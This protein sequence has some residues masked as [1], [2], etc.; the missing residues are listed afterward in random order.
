MNEVTMRLRTV[1]NWLIYNGKAENEKGVADLLGYTKS[2][3][4]QIVN[5]KIALSDKFVRK[6]CSLD[7]KINGNWV[8]TGE[9]EMLKSEETGKKGDTEHQIPLL[10]I[11]AIG[12]SLNGYNTQVMPSDC[13]TITVP[14]KGAE[15]AVTVHGDSMAPEYPSGSIVLIKKI[16]ERAFI[17]WGNVFVIDTINGVIVKRLLPCKD[18]EGRVL[19]ESNN[20][21]FAPFELSL[22][23]VRGIY[24]ILMC[25]I[26]K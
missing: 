3:F 25:M 21:K 9:G 11:N 7:D 26:R 10:P 16:D 5:N 4:S 14:I 22:S 12:G 1:I 2:S 6:L 8:K 20:E 23:D 17:E 24:R 15:M 13:E 18:N 19:C